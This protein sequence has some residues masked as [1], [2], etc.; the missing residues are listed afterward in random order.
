MKKQIILLSA[1]FAVMQF[2]TTW[3]SSNLQ[4]VV[5]QY[6]KSSSA[7]QVHAI[8]KALMHTDPSQTFD[9]QLLYVIQNYNDPL[10]TVQLLMSFG[11]KPS[12]NT[13]SFVKKIQGLYPAK[14]ANVSRVLQGQKIIDVSSSKAVAGRS[15]Q[16]MKL[17]TLTVGQKTSIEKAIKA[18]D[19][20]KLQNYFINDLKFRSY[21][22]NLAKDE[23]YSNTWFKDFIKNLQQLESY[24]QDGVNR[25]DQNLLNSLYSQSAVARAFVK[26]LAKDPQNVWL[27]RVLPSL[28]AKQT[29]WKAEQALARARSAE[30]SVV[31]SPAV[32]GYSESGMPVSEQ[33]T[34]GKRIWMP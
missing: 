1:L 7:D 20:S 27:K 22:I 26:Q 3:S 34:G 29:V 33:V 14:F 15:G 21:M 9:E 13:I 4:K 28:K 5:E 6:K 2:G 31:Q 23:K 24:V 19:S 25:Q 11:A 18:K 8:R 12:Q 10:P 32:Y 30:A 17:P 16:N